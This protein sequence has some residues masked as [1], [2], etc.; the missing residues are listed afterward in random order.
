MGTVPSLPQ[1]SESSTSDADTWRPQVGRI[2]DPTRFFHVAWPVTTMTSS[3]LASRRPVQA[4][5]SPPQALQSR[6]HVRF[7]PA[8][9]SA[10]D[11]RAKAART[12]K[13]SI[14]IHAG[15]IARM[16]VV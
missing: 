11:A 8:S 14:S 6:G 12:T 4:V 2:M 16:P 5:A 1:A 10:A 13:R 7:V 3:S 15:S 9:Q